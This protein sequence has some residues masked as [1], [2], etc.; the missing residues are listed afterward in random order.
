MSFNRIFTASRNALQARKANANLVKSM[1]TKGN[2]LFIFG[3]FQNGI[4]TQS[5]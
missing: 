4:L 3:N 2:F 1:A 5:L